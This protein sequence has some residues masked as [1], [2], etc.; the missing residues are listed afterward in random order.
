[1]N[2]CPIIEMRYSHKGAKCITVK[3]QKKPRVQTPA[4]KERN[5]SA[6]VSLEI[7]REGYVHFNE[8]MQYLRKN[9]CTDHISMAS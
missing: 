2:V 5:V 6:A 3:Q 7:M 9:V 4:G 1:M 8:A